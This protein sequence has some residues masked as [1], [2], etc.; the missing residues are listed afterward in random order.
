MS[1]FVGRNALFTFLVILVLMMTIGGVYSAEMMGMDGDMHNCPFMGVAALCNM[2]PLQH[3]SQWQLMFSVISKQMNVAALLLL[4]ALAILW[5]LSR[6][7]LSVKRT[8]GFVSHYRYRKRVFDP[9]R[10][11][12]ARGIIHSKA[13]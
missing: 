6:D 12:F 2:S 3:L 5:H 9:L 13:Y 11:A 1:R 7:L 4:L 8:E 10:L